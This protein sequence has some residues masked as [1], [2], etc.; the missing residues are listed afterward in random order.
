MDEL[1]EVCRKF[2]DGLC[3][4]EDLYRRL[5]WIAVPDQF[6]EVVSKAE[7]DLEIIQFTEVEEKWHCEGMRVL[8]QLLKELGC[9]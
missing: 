3:T 7:K 9:K 8:E 1:I 2:Q 4:I 5:S 6:S